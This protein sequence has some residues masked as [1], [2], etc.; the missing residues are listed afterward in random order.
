MPPCVVNNGRM[1]HRLFAMDS[2]FRMRKMGFVSV[3]EYQLLLPL[4]RKRH[5]VN[6]VSIIKPR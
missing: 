1:I 6:D 5:R 3:A 2:D 4:Q